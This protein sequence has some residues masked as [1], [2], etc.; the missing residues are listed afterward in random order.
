MILFFGTMNAMPMMYAKAYRSLGKQVTYYVDVAKS[1]GLSRPE[2]HFADIEYP[3]PSWIVERVL[4]TQLL[5]SLFPRITKAMMIRRR[6][7]ASGTPEAVFLGGYFVAFAPF[8]PKHTRK[9]FLSYG[10]DLERWVDSSKADAVYEAVKTTSIF[11]YLPSTIGRWFVNKIIERNARGAKACDDVLFFPRGMSQQGDRVVDL[12]GSSGVRYIPRYDISMD[13]LTGITREVKPRGEKL[14]IVSPVRFFYKDLPAVFA[15]EC[16]GNDKI[17]RGIAA[18]RQKTNANIEVHFFE[19]GPHVD[20][21]KMLCIEL[22]LQDVV[23]WHKT[24]PLDRLLEMY[25]AADVIFDQVGSHWVGA[26]GMYALYMGK[27]LIAN[28]D[29]LSSLG[30]VPA[31]NAR[32]SDEVAERLSEVHTGAN[33]ADLHRLSKIFADTAIGPESVIAKLGI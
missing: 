15:H 21:A 17:I 11:K 16:K 18:F 24:V 9:V 1:N 32:T 2:N 6:S 28:I 29:N 23:V 3:Y 31:L 19:K 30:E 20:D 10:S 5:A 25:A 14:V 13:A 27:P 4:P 33:L 26:V 22:G 12:L 7:A 8:F